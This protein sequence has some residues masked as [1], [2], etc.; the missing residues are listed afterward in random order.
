MPRP[1]LALIALAL[2]LTT[3]PAAPV[4]REVRRPSLYLPTT[5]GA[6]WVYQLGDREYTRTVAEVR[7]E[8]GMAV[9]SIGETL[10][11]EGP[12]YERVAVSKA[13]LTRVEMNGRRFD[14]PHVLL[15]L[16]PEPGETWE[17]AGSAA[18]FLTGSKFMTRV[19]ERVGVPAGTF[20]SVPVE[21]EYEVAGTAVRTTT[22]YAPGV[23]MVKEVSWDGRTRA[24]KAFTPCQD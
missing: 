9:V 24:L 5:V 8:G 20:W 13:G 1:L 23:G 18:K 19:P 12:P 6:R 14:P 15:K 22:W 4:P 16:P 2:L 21:M 3:A 7:Q 10:H 17:I 11:D